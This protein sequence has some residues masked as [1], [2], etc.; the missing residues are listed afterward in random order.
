MI[1]AGHPD[2]VF[3]LEAFSAAMPRHW[4]EPADADAVQ[5]GPH[6][7]R[8]AARAP[9]GEPRSARAPREGSGLAGVRG[10]RLLRLPSQPDARGRQLAAGAGLRAPRASGPAAAAGVA[11]PHRAPRAAGVGRAR[12]ATELDGVMGKLQ[13][14]ASRLSAQ[15][16][17]SRRARHAGAG[18]RRS[19]HQPR[20]DVGG[21]ARDGHAML[22]GIFADAP[23]IAERGERAAEQ[24][25]M[26]AEVLATALAKARGQDP[27]ATQA[28]V[29]G[30]VPAVRVP[31][32]L[33][34]AQ[35]RRRR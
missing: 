13:I 23:A 9:P 6:V 35:V 16:R 2:L 3:E 11:L 25:A 22:R 1:A 21:D 24:A 33:R 4:K 12:R 5:A 26:A 17:R 14:E 7:R 15:A 29:H 18:H 8:R 10:A 30:A 34:P 28:R 20:A 32:Q 31:Q 19:R 27:A